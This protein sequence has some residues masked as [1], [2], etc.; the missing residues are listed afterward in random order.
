MC[1]S[2]CLL[3]ASRDLLTMLGPALRLSQRQPIDFFSQHQVPPAKTSCR[4]KP[5]SLQVLGPFLTQGCLS[6]PPSA[7]PS[8]SQL[9]RLSPNSQAFSPLRR[10]LPLPSEGSHS[11]VQPQAT[12]ATASPSTRQSH[13]CNTAT[14]KGLKSSTLEPH[15]WLSFLSSL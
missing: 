10:P 12:E 5:R 15:F 3:Q 8:I 9:V 4:M 13:T 1:V 2:V 7:A 14:R 11:S 6:Q